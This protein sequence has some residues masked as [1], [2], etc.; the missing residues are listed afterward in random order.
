MGIT[1]VQF[2]EYLKSCRENAK[3]TQEQLV[4]DLYHSD[5]ECFSSLETTTLSKWERGVIKPRLSKQVAILKY[6]QDQTGLALPCWQDLSVD[7]AEE[8]I[9]KIGMRNLVGKSKELILNFPDAMMGADDLE[10]HQLRNTEMIEEIIDVQMNLDKS[11]NHDTTGITADMFKDWAMVPSN[12]F[13]ICTYNKQFFGLL[14]SLRL[15]LESFE[16][17]MQ[18]ELQEK[19]LNHSDFADYNEPAS[20]YVIAFFA[21]NEKV[22]SMLFIRYYAHL[23]ANQ[24]VINEVGTATMMVDVTKMIESLNFKHCHSKRLNDEL[25]WQTYREKLPAFLASDNV[26]KMILSKQDCPEG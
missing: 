6:F 22:S 9:C 26:V 20:N 11:F 21:M 10:V 18:C 7:E 8:K 3:L 2:N 15:K 17:L 13:Y 14:F 16:K 25:V 5:I 24:K 19:E 23:I 1:K 12:S 4:E